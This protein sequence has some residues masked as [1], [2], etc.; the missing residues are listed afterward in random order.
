MMLISV[1][2]RFAK[3]IFN[4]EKTIELRKSAPKR[5]QRGTQ[6]LIYVTSP[7]KEL[8]GICQIENIIKDSPQKLWQK[9]GKNSGISYEEFLSYYQENSNAYGIEICNVQ[10]FWE[11]SIKLSYL[12][13]MFPGFSPPQTYMYLEE[14]TIANSLLS[15]LIC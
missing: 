10:N 14:E 9:V 13:T 12:K 2:P 5:A 6:L 8:W 4:G 1:K 11:N 3:K 15:K 7:V